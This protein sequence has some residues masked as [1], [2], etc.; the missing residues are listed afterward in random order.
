MADGLA[1]TG[2]IDSDDPDNLN[3]LFFANRHEFLMVFPWVNSGGGEEVLVS[4]ELILSGIGANIP[5]VAA[6]CLSSVAFLAF[7]VPHAGRSRQRRGMSVDA[8]EM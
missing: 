6:L 7:I 2:V 5:L 4:N 3:I 1:A 8:D